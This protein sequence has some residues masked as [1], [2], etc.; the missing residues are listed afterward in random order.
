MDKNL[1][2]AEVSNCFFVAMNNRDFSKDES[3]LDKS[4]KLDFPGVGI[5]EGPKR[6]I[7]FTKT[8]Q[9]K[10]P[11][12]TFNVNDIVSSENSHKELTD[13]VLKA[14][15]TIDESQKYIT[16][17]LVSVSLS[18]LSENDAVH[19]GNYMTLAHN[20]EKYADHL[21]HIALIFDKIERQQL[22]LS[23]AARKNVVEIFKENSNFY[24][25]S[26]SA[27]IEPVDPRAF[28]EGAQVTNRRIKK[29]I[30]LSW[31]FQDTLLLQ[32]KAGA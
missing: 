7:I 9:R 25:T 5:I 22:V 31:L 2:I 3:I 27:L 18:P 24:T 15:K 1:S 14:E 13:D 20:L 8:I 32:K 6:L 17:F 26:F 19:I 12:L 29:L 28:M 30:K 10:F 16:E 21:E 23:D 4:V 11:G